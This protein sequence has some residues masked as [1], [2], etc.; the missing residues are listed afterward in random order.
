[1]ET[2]LP[3]QC[4]KAGV[5]SCTLLS[6]PHGSFPPKH[7]PKKISSLASPGNSRVFSIR[8]T[9][10][11][12]GGAGVLFRGLG[13]T[14]AVLPH[15]RARYLGLVAVCKAAAARTRPTRARI[16]HGRRVTDREVH[17]GLPEVFKVI[18]YELAHRDPK[19]L[20]EPGWDPGK[21]GGNTA[22]G[23][24]ECRW[25]LRRV[26]ALPGDTA[27]HFHRHSRGT[28]PAGDRGS[29]TSSASVPIDKKVLADSAR[30]LCSLLASYPAGC[31]SWDP[32][33]PSEWICFQTPHAK[34]SLS[35]LPAMNWQP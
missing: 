33:A 8:P 15:A 20:Q 34:G 1:M 30:F 5:T 28:R 35:P 23:T 26:A 32:V 12:S 13:D 25:C 3:C 7:P 2:C 4:H 19:A 29:F 22:V 6:R 16:R 31:L 10:P 18:N 21:G 9:K 11:R 27:R 14:P 24:P 17:V